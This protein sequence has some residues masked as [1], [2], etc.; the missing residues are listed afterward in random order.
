MTTNLGWGGT[1]ILKYN[2]LYI[3]GTKDG[4]HA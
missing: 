1:I 3:D 2:P 4:T